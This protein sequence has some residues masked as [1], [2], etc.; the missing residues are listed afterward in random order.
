MVFTQAGFSPSADEN[1]LQCENLQ[2]CLPLN[3]ILS[4]IHYFHVLSETHR[5]YLLHAFSVIP[6]HIKSY[7]FVVLSNRLFY[8]L[9]KYKPR[10]I[11]SI[12]L[13]TNNIN[14][15][16]YI[17]FILFIEQNGSDKLQLVWNFLQKLE[18]T[19]HFK[20]WCSRVHTGRHI[21]NKPQGFYPALIHITSAQPVR[22][23]RRRRIPSYQECLVYNHRLAI[24][25]LRNGH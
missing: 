23:F 22:H 2:N 16:V 21:T 5:K 12:E 20:E 24:S 18:I 1:H 17:I 9:C 15:D 6:N 10:H 3:L 11:Q 19:L 7:Q 4:H 13:F 8:L 25:L 14:D